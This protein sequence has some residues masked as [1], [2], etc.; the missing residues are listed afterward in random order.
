MNAHNP[1][2]NSVSTIDLELEHPIF[3]WIPFTASPDDPHGAELYA[4]AI[5]GAFGPVEQYMPP[6]PAPTA[7]PSSG[8]ITALRQAAY[9]AES[10]PL[11]FK[12][13]RGEST[14]ADWKA[15]IDIIKGRYPY[16]EGYSATPSSPTP[17]T[18]TIPTE[19]L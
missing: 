14:E 16:P 17:A 18:G 7:T 13:Q 9:Q 8:E 5:L 12:W 6:E 11:F 19:V 1:K 2:H 10:D 15:Q 4:Q 3:G